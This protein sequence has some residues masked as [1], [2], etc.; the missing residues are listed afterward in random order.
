MF[1]H[2]KINKDNAE[3]YVIRVLK[4]AR[5]L[6]IEYEITEDGKG[7]FYIVQPDG[8]EKEITLDQVLG[9]EEYHSQ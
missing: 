1:D 5:E 6:G 4:A 7:G 3:E 9:I 2:L 8:T